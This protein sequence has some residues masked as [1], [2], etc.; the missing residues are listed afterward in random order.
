MKVFGV[1]GSVCLD[2][3]KQLLFRDWISMQPEIY[4]NKSEANSNLQLYENEGYSCEVVEMELFGNSIT[5]K[6]EKKCH[7][8]GRNV[9]V[10]DKECWYCLSKQL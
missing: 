1:F 2:T 6:A 9:D 8:C 5:M 7:H 4:I 3:P 10:T